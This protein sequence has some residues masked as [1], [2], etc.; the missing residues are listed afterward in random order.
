MPTLQK[1]NLYFQ[2]SALKVSRRRN[3]WV[4]KL[5]QRV[6]Q[7]NDLVAIENLLVR[8][9]VSQRVGRVS[10]LEATGDSV[11]LVSHR[12]SPVRVKNHCLAKSIDLLQKSPNTPP[13]APKSLRGGESLT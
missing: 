4:C 1:I 6:I 13:P 7:S 2:S 5:A 12:A 9:L 3:D 11:A 10:R 8:N